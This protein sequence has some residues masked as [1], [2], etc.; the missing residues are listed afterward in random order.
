MIADWD[1][2]SMKSVLE[3]S[4]LDESDDWLWQGYLRPGDITLLTSLWKT[5]KTTL[6]AGMLRCLETGDGIAPRL[7]T[8]SQWL[9][10]RSSSCAR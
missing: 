2:L 4:P 5:G 9:A 3:Q 10:C 7:S 8:G 6:L 1:P